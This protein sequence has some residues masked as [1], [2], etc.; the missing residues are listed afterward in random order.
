MCW[1]EFKCNTPSSSYLSVFQALRVSYLDRR[2]LLTITS[3]KQ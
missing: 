1:E 2:T 3:L